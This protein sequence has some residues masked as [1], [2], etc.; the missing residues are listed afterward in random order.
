MRMRV[1]KAYASQA[2]SYERALCDAPVC[3][4]QAPNQA[5][6]SVVREQVTERQLQVPSMRNC[7]RKQ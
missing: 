5:A 4:R 1:Q 3:D 2:V 6:G 7:W